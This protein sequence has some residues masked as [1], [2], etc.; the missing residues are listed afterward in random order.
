MRF[1]MVAFALALLTGCANR[2]VGNP[3]QAIDTPYYMEPGA[4]S[5]GPGYQPMS[6]PPSACGPSS[7]Q[8]CAPRPAHPRPR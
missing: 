6:L 7:S 5:L 4:A 8:S 1:L 2:N 3:N